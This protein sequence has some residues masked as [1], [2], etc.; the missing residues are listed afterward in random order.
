[1]IKYFLNSPQ[2]DESELEAMVQQVKNV[3]ATPQ[4]MF[5]NHIRPIMRSGGI[6][7]PYPFESDDDS[8]SVLELANRRLQELLAEPVKHIDRETTS[9]IFNEVPGLLPRLNVYQ[10]V[11]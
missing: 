4:K 2:V 9:R 6:S 11:I 1:M 3:M 7:S 5:I 10:E 8:D